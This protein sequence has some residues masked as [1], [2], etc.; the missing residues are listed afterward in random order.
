MTRLCQLLRC[1]VLQLSGAQRSCC[2]RSRES[3]P[4]LETIFVRLFDYSGLIPAALTS[5][6]FDAISSR[7]RASNCSGVI[8]M[9]TT[10]RAASLSR[11]FADCMVFA[12]SL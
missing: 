4:C 6:A 10:P 5:G 3:S 8:D 9:G 11:T 2:Q 12:V 7:T 1:G